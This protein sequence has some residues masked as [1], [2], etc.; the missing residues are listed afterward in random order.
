MRSEN[1]K[2]TSPLPHTSIIHTAEECLGNI[3]LHLHIS[4]FLLPPRNQLSKTPGAE[5]KPRGEAISACC[6]R[7]QR[8]SSLQSDE[9]EEKI[10]RSGG[11]GGWFV[12]GVYLL[13]VLTSKQ[14]CERCYFLLAFCLA[15]SV[16]NDS[17]SVDGLHLIMVRLSLKWQSRRSSKNFF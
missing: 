17:Y 16:K 8:A 4:S 15:L 7:N 11:G 10:G 1:S 13:I 6:L 2:L 5:T 9:G 12:I 3:W 14:V